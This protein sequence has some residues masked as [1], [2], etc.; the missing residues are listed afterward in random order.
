MF[1]ELFPS[2]PVAEQIRMTIDPAMPVLPGVWRTPEERFSSLSGYAFEPHYKAA[3]PGFEGLR[4]HYLD[5]G[6]AD[7]DVTVLCLHGQ[8]TWSYLYRRMLPVFVGE[9]PKGRSWRGESHLGACRS[10][11]PTTRGSDRQTLQS[12]RVFRMRRRDPASGMLM[13]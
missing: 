1:L 5:E 8:P 11:G 10:C 12:E 13:S 6:P 2:F 9:H 4:V 7:A 3:L